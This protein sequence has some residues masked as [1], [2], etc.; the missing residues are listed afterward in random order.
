[1][2]TINHPSHGGMSDFINLNGMLLLSINVVCIK[3]YDSTRFQDFESKIMRNNLMMCESSMPKIL[4]EVVNSMLLRFDTGCF[5]MPLGKL[6]NLIDDEFGE[7]RIRQL[8]HDSLYSQIG[9]ESNPW[10]GNHD[11]KK[12][13]CYK[14]SAQTDIS[15]YSI[16]DRK[17]LLRFINNNC[18]A[19]LNLKDF[20]GNEGFIEGTF[21]IVIS[22]N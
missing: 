13:F 2:S 18:E 10:D 5:R 21:E 22:A 8:V 1:M 12:V 19:V 7:W 14:S 17:E 16:Y 15:F 20:K 9:D 3:T 4:G 11:F 6:D